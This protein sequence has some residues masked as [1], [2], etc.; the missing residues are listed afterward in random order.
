MLTNY[1]KGYP[2]LRYPPLP[3]MSIAEFTESVPMAEAE[4]SPAVPQYLPLSNL[5]LWETMSM[6]FSRDSCRSR[7]VHLGTYS[8]MRAV[9]DPR[10]RARH[11][12]Q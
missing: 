3:T 4:L 12:Y 11:C 1:R 7:N 10:C 8:L 5:K 6:I 2:S 9:T